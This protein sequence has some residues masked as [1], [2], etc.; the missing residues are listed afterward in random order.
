LF[1]N[2][3]RSKRV[4]FITTGFGIVSIILSIVGL[5]LISSGLS[6]TLRNLFH[7]DSN[8]MILKMTGLARNRSLLKAVE[9]AP[10]VVFGSALAF[11]NLEFL[12]FFV[13]DKKMKK[14]DDQEDSF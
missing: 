10:W 6:F 13:V 9:T 4:F 1:K 11:V 3:K 14:I 5:I 2:H 8:Q 12:A 7:S